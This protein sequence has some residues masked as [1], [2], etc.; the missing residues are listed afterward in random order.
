MAVGKVCIKRLGSNDSRRSVVF[1]SALAVEWNVLN[2]H[3][4]ISQRL[5]VTLDVHGSVHHN[6]NLIEMTNKMQQWRE[7]YLFHCSL[8]ARHVS[9]YIIA[10][11][12][13]L[14][15]C[16]YSFWFYTRLS[17]PA[18]VMAER[19]LFISEQFPLNCSVLNSSHSA[20]TAADKD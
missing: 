11:N 18:A 15:N 9:S 1:H 20:M 7:I 14:L 16:N 8:T 19:E 12:Q 2:L 17:L 5:S 6:T 3:L 4:F 13:E 10:H